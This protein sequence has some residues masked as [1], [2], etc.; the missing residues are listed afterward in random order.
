MSVKMKY[1]A[2]LNMGEKFDV[3]DGFVHEEG[4]KLK[5]GG[6]VRTQLEKDLMWDKIKQIGGEQPQDIEADIKVHI[7]DYYG[8]YT[9]VSGDTLGKISKMFLG[10]PSRYMDI[11]NINRDQLNN[12]DLIKVGQELKI[13]FK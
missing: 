3:K 6:W 10:T 4:D 5:I 7:E 9:V 13:P 11:F 12:P 8:I 2:V 1:Q